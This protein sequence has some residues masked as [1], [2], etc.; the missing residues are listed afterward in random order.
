V[1]LW[2]DS[3]HAIDAANDATSRSANNPTNNAT[4]RSEHAVTGIGTAVSPVIHPP[5]HALRLYSDRPGEKEADSNHTEHSHLVSLFFCI[6][7]IVLDDVGRCS[8]THYARPERLHRRVPGR[9]GVDNL[10]VRASR[11]RSMRRRKD[12]R[13]GLVFC[14]RIASRSSLGEFA[15]VSR[16]QH[17][18]H[19]H[20]P[21]QLGSGIATIGI[22]MV[23][24]GEVGP[25][26]RE[27][28]TAKT[29][30]IL[31]DRSH[32]LWSF[33]RRSVASGKR[34]E[35]GVARSPVT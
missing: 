7:P 3:E 6:T 9:C 24:H 30:H 23:P 26:P 13:H 28:E 17:G 11:P 27:Q 31:C 12:P 32:N 8:A 21:P 1:G 19:L 15:R 14:S 5:R 33:D 16:P 2:I 18:K 25:W 29:P 4:D 35:F 10:V 22:K 20:S 34:L